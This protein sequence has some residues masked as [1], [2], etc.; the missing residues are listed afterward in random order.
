MQGD[1]TRYNITLYLEKVKIKD[2]SFCLLGI[3][4]PNDSNYIIMESVFEKKT[5]TKN[6]YVFLFK[7]KDEIQIVI[8]V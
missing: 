4:R 7:D 6:I 2:Q 1:N 3:Q 5:E 8:S